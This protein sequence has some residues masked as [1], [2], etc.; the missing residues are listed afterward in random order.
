MR[1]TLSSLPKQIQNSIP[2]SIRSASDSYNLNELPPKIQELIR[3][4]VSSS[5]E[6]TYPSAFDLKP[7]ISKYSDLY[8]TPSVKETVVEYLKNYFYTLPGSYPFDPSFGC[9]LKYHLQTR[10]VQLRKLLISDEINNIVNILSSD[11]GLPITVEKISINPISTVLDSSYTCN[12]V[13]SIPGEESITFDLQ[14]FS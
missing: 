9:K 1:V 12:I 7:R 4:Y 3:E 14:S 8:V 11:L 2:V 6:V 10:D 13:M 5:V